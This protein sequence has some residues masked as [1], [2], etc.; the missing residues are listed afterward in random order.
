MDGQLDL[1][2][3]N[4]VSVGATSPNPG[5]MVLFP[6]KK[7]T[8]VFSAS[9]N[10]VTAVNNATQSVAQDSAGNTEALTLP[11]FTESIV[12]APDNAT[13]FAAIPTALGERAISGR[14]STC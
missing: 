13:G 10:S 4:V 1:I 6:N 3:P 5:L 7:L 14:G 8:L 9:N 2:S 12:V 11:G